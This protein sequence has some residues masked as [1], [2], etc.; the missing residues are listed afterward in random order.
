V[1]RFAPEKLF[2]V[3]ENYFMSEHVISCRDMWFH[4]GCRENTTLDM[5]LHFGDMKLQNPDM[6]MTTWQK[7]FHVGNVQI[8]C[9]REKISCRREGPLSGWKNRPHKIDPEISPT[10]LWEIRAAKKKF[11]LTFFHVGEVQFYTFFAQLPFSPRHVFA[12]FFR[13][14]YIFLYAFWLHF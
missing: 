5:K 2:H 10:Q 12:L 11:F 3:G 9:R 7:I 6:K 8:S 4:V 13:T 14:I 1:A